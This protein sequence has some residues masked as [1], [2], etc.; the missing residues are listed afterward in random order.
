ME[1]STVGVRWAFSYIMHLFPLF[2]LFGCFGLLLRLLLSRRR[3]EVHT[4]AFGNSLYP[5]HRLA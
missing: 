3:D 4:F 1:A 5:L 2:R